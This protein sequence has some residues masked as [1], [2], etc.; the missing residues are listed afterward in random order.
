VSPRFVIVSD[1]GAAL[2]G[3]QLTSQWLLRAAAAMQVQLTA[4]IA[5]AW[6]YA[7]GAV[8]R[9][10]STT[11]D[12]QTGEIAM[13]YV[14]TLPDAPGAEA[15]HDDAGATPDEFLALDTCNTLGDVSVGHSH[16]NAEVAGDPLCN[17]VVPIPSG[18]HLPP[19]LSVGSSLA[20][21]IADPVQDRSYPIDLGDGLPPIMVSDFVLPP[22]FDPTIKGPTTYGEAYCNLAHVDPFGRTSGGYQ[23]VQAPNGNESQAFGAV[24]AHKLEAARRGVSTSRLFLRGVRIP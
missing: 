13:R 8:V 1:P 4:H 11:T 19:G 16:E 3:S 23:I 2:L 14:P 12:V 20:L 22:Y 24:P 18:I 5:P 6:P 10:A 7:L 21:E 17:L 9:V 15:Y